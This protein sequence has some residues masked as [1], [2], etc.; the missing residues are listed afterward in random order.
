MSDNNSKPVPAN[1]GPACEGES[2]IVE[3]IGKEHPEGHAFRIFDESNNEQQEWLEKQVAVEILDDSVLH[4]WPWKGQ[5]RRNIWI[6]IEAEGAPIRVPFLE[7]AGSIDRELERQHHVILPIVPAT[8]IS[9]VELQGDNPV[10]HVLA[11]AGFLYLFHEGKLWRELEIRI[12][13]SGVTSYSDVALYDYR[14][15]SGT[16]KAGYR[17]VTGTG[18]EEIWLPARVNGGWLSLQAA[19]SESQWPGERINHLERSVRDRGGRCNTV[20]MRFNADGK[21]G[22]SNSKIS[23][24]AT[25]A[26]LALHMESQR[27]R[28]PALEW[29]F[30]RPEKYLLDLNANYADIARKEALSLHQR[31]EDPDPEDP[32]AEDERAEMTALSNCL[33]NT[34][35]ELIRSDEPEPFSWAEVEPC[36]ADCTEQAKAR[37][38]GVIRLDDPIY[39]LRYNQRRRQVAAWF[40]NAAVRRAKVRPY[41]DSALLV[42]SVLEPETVASKPNSLHKHMAEVSGHG[43]KE[44]ERSLALSERTLAR[45]YLEEIHTDLLARLSDERTHHVLTDLFTHYSYDYAGAFNF[46]TTLVMNLVTEPAECD[47][48]SIG[49]EGA[50]DGQ[51]K[52]W[53]EGLCA[54]RH[55]RVLRLL[56]FPRY[57]AEDLKKPY[58]P[59]TEPQTNR[60]NGRFRDAELAAMA[61]TD[62]L[63][64][65][66]L[67]TIDGLEISIEAAAGSYATLLT[68][69][70]RMG[71][72]VLMSVHGN[73]WA[74]I[75]HASHGIQARNRELADVNKEL[76]N[77][78]LRKA[79]L[80][81]QRW[82]TERRIT[83]LKGQ[84]VELEDI[85]NKLSQMETR[86]QELALQ[87]QALA[88][89]AILGR[90]KLYSNSLEQLRRSL[91]R[92]LGQ[93]ELMRFS[94]ALQK[95]YFVFEIS[96]H[97]LG[98][99]GDKEAIALFGDF[100][101]QEGS[102][103][104]LASTNKRR[105]QAAA[106]A[107]EVAEDA[108][109]LVIP[110]TEAI[111]KMIAEISAAESRFLNSVH[112]LS[113]I[114]N[115]ADNFPDTPTAAAAIA[116]RNLNAARE[117]MERAKKELKAFEQD[118]ANQKDLTRQKEQ[119]VG[120]LKAAND[121]ANQIGQAEI[122]SKNSSRLYRVLNKPVF[123]LFVGLMELHNASSVWAAYNYQSRVKGSRS[124]NIK[125]FSA[126]A[127]LLAA[128][129]AISERWMLGPSKVLSLKLSGK[130]GQAFT[131]RLG[132][133]LTIRSGL[134]AAAGFLMALDAGF[135]S[136]YEYRMGNNAAAVGYGLIAGS[137]VAFG[138]ASLVGKPGLLLVL[139]PKGWL[140]A[141]VVLA[142]AGLATVFAFSDEPLDV[143]MRHGPFGSM[144]EKPFLKEPDI[145][146]HRLISLLMGVSVR[147]E[148]N[149]L[150]Q[151]A[152]EGGF[153]GETA[154]RV[155]ALSNAS[156]R[157]VID[158]AIPGLFSSGMFAKVT[159]ELQLF[160][161]IAVTR[162]RGQA[163]VNKISGE[164]I[165]KH[166]LLT[167]QSETGAHIYLKAP[168][169][170]RRQLDSWPW[171]R[172]VWETKT[173]RWRAKVQIQARKAADGLLMVFPAPP[174]EDPLTFDQDNELHSKPN[175]K[176]IRQ[177]YWYTQ[178]VQENVE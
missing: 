46:V 100:I 32:I 178:R 61:E 81:N 136:Y 108:Y 126:G 122:D 161:T 72:Q 109:V 6:E 123:P 70:L 16:L 115:L 131:R 116:T 26:F 173:Y 53:L 8:L 106:I 2:L 119:Y 130:P 93:M 138:F 177:P 62:L 107:S 41:F 171:E 117:E 56:L 4:V 52:Q 148:Y 91:P 79:E 5:P 90:M 60:G 11:R 29:Q 163:W 156:E 155:A 111:A 30:D 165:K 35:Q 132:T 17:E 103:E 125:M 96:K 47:A 98:S 87:K 28:K 146:Y 63:E 33:H 84:K 147:M 57:S 51:G 20:S 120:D 85:R 58:K 80:E 142:V 127:D 150:R 42:H 128:A 174:P 157:L 102:K 44:L 18:L 48:L 143:W 110:K 154:E 162:G 158:S 167:E 129:T 78:R 141:G 66:D 113:E 40:M 172:D 10:H 9:G 137:G 76:E 74:A 69:N 64:I 175:F 86:Y 12:D 145:A 37:G 73:M 89:T 77:L 94:K 114:E 67:K 71:S 59:P 159:V 22:T 39:Q 36:V 166:R 54:G 99:F 153:E 121:A 101:Q 27:P 160:E 34:L 140:V 68:A 170:E 24:E 3:V 15:T 14:Q 49:V 45:R 23:S 82:A 152:R 38:I 88:E 144:A 134:G 75:H 55:S 149:P 133:P 118:A 168:A 139:G 124:G 1:C 19:Y 97:R 151:Q 7:S 92:L 164:G 176:Q 112:K 25:S 95:D 31:H 50:G 65:D 169:N 83:N 105:S 21:E 135:D 104:V 43:R 13:E